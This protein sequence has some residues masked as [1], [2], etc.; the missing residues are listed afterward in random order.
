MSNYSNNTNYQNQATYPNAQPQPPIYNPP[1]YQPQAGLEPP[2]G[3]RQKNRVVAG[4]LAMLMGS[5]G[6]HSF[7]MGNNSRGL[8]Q[9]LVTFLGCGVGAICMMIWGVIDGVKILDGR[10]NTDAYGI[11]LKD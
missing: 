11:H 3:Y 1:Q 2:P 8:T 9:I 5:L 4:V 6:L 7:Y 10:I